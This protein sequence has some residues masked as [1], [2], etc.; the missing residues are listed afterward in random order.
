LPVLA[1]IHFTSNMMSQVN[2]QAVK[3]AGGLSIFVI[4]LPEILIGLPLLLVTWAA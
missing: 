1:L 4:I 3:S 2:A